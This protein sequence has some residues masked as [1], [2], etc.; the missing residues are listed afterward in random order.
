MGEGCPPSPALSAVSAICCCSWRAQPSFSSSGGSSEQSH[1][2]NHRLRV[3]YRTRKDR[4]MPDKSIT[5]VSSEYAPKGRFGQKYLASG[6]HISMRL[7][8]REQLCHRQHRQLPLPAALG[9]AVGRRHLVFVRWTASQSVLSVRQQ[10]YL[11]HGSRRDL[12]WKSNVINSRLA[13]E[14]VQSCSFR[15]IKELLF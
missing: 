1:V 6:I 13:N 2:P 9:P 4:N 15:N 14:A 7:W 5:K 3:S 10:A 11:L 12:P 8:E